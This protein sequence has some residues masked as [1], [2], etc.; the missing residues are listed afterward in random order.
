MQLLLQNA[1]LEIA[2]ARIIG[3]GTFIHVALASA[4]TR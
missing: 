2:Q 1:I 4:A 3:H